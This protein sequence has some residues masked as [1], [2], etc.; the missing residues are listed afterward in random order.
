VVAH[1]VVGMKARI[2]AHSYL[3]DQLAEQLSI[4]RREEDVLTITAKRDVM[5]R[6]GYVDSQWSRHPAS[7]LIRTTLLVHLAF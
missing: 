6:S 4:A 7:S 1:E 3:S 2:E 5:H